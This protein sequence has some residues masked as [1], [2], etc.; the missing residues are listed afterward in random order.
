MWVF[1]NLAF[2]FGRINNAALRITKAT[3]TTELTVPYFHMISQP[4]TVIVY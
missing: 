1:E 3:E 4:F 2:L